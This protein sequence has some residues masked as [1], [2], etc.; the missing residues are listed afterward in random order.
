VDAS[1]RRSWVQ[2][3]RSVASE[4]MWRRL[5]P[6]TVRPARPTCPLLSPRPHIVV[7]CV[8]KGAQCRHDLMVGSNR[9]DLWAIAADVNRCR[10]I[11]RPEG[12]LTA[13]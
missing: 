2:P 12:Y 13:D 4:L 5:A 7:A 9:N 10:E 1:P 6:L 8:V 11:D 3:G